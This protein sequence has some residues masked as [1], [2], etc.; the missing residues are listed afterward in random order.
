V[1]PL[2]GIAG[3]GLASLVGATATARLPPV[4]DTPRSRSAG[5][6]L[7][8][9]LGAPGVRTV[10]LYAAMVGVAFG[11]VE[12]GMPAFTEAHGSREL[13]GV[14]LACFSGGS[15]VGGLVAG[16]RPPRSVLHRFAAGS[17]LLGGALG[18]LLL[19]SSIPTLC[20]LA[21]VAGLPIAPTIGALYTVI[22]RTARAGTAAEA[23]A[24][25]GTAVS[26]GI[27]TGAV[28]AGVLVDE[29]GVRSAFAAGAAVALC[30]ALL[31]WAR[32]GTLRRAA[33][34]ADA[35]STLIP[36]RP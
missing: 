31:G 19:A 18:A 33:D 36:E 25:F 34:G 23:F 15:L 9:A 16:L 28:L 2:A 17:V 14:A 5:A 13:G 29:R 22:D 30:G 24:W 27:A 3:A 10:V 21:F 32:R 8:G 6:G 4:R 35:G 7:L 20:A 26:T 1:S 11:S 12:L